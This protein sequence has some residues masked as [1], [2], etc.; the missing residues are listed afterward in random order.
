[1]RFGDAGSRRGGLGALAAALIFALSLPLALESHAAITVQ[2][3]PGGRF[4]V[5]VVPMES[6]AL[7]RRFGEDVAEEI[8]ERLADFATHAP[9]PERE[10][11]RALKRYEV[12]QEEL[13]AIRAR[14]LANLMG[15]HVV[16]WG[17]VRAA[18]R[19]YEVEA[20]FIDV[21]T[22]E[23]VPVPTVTIADRSDESVR[24]VTD[25]AIDAFE[26]QVRFLRARQFCAEYV[27]S[28]QPENALR[29]CNEALTI[30][31]SSINALYHK[32]LAFRQLFENDSSGSAGW[33]DSAV[34]YFLRVLESDPG[35]RAAMQNAAYI[36]S[37]VGDA[38]KASEYYR[39]YLELDP[40][41]V[42]VRLRVAYDMAEVGLMAEA[43]AIIQEGLAHAPTDTTLLQQL[44]DYALRYSDEDSTYVDVAL[45]AYESVLEIKG[46]QTDIRIIENT[47]AAY[48]RGN[49]ITEA[50]A[51][52][53][54]ALQSH[55]DSPR[56]WSLY[57]DALSR[58]D[59]YSEAATAMDRV[60]ELEPGYANGYLKRGQFKLQG[61]DEAAAMA[62]FNYAIETGASTSDDVF[63]LFWSEAH[64]A[65][66]RGDFGT[67]VQ[68]FQRAQQFVAASQREELE[69]WWA[70]TYYQLGERLAQ[71][72]DAGLNQLQRAQANFQAAMGHFQQAGSVRREVPQLREATERWLLNVEARIRQLSR[73]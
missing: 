9:I 55:P 51:F 67:A 54:R 65:R 28:Q 23:E 10:F 71:P 42:P 2:Q 15:A 12:K 62:D 30:N 34:A 22:G 68:H 52:A 19:A 48:T 58:L 11:E 49:R 57:A 31:P 8:S 7:H 29:N 24:Q 45:Q 13:N 44:G 56:L 38:E 27:N 40:G 59:R 5:L 33:G 72:E 3:E 66:N 39:T 64:G 43:I 60:L 70:Y 50:V 1:M 17:S 36:Y 14:Q 21:A 69:F 61:G 63:R 32:G 37:Q 73:R 20:S 53:E 4:R 26:T 25:A 47:I 6:S 35:H 18:G 41:N 16:F 46:E